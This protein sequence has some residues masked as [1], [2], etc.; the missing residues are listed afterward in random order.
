M[1]TSQI[2][3]I[4]GFMVMAVLG[5]I[6]IQVRQIQQ[7]VMVSEANFHASV[8]DA[9]NEVVDHMQGEWLR[10]QFVRVS[11]S[12][13]VEIPEGDETDPLSIR[14][15]EKDGMIPQQRVLI[16]DRLAII[17]EQEAFLPVDSII[18]MGGNMAYVYEFNDSIR[19]QEN[20]QVE[21]RGHPR[22][23]QMVSSALT[24]MEGT[25]LPFPQTWD[26]MG[27]D[28]MIRQALHNKGIFL[29]YDY[30]VNQLDE[31][32]P[33]ADL[34]RT[35]VDPEEM[36][37]HHRVKMFPYIKTNRPSYLEVNFTGDRMFQ[38]KQVW[39]QAGLALIFTLVILLSF[40]FTLRVIFRQKR[41]SEMKTDF[42]NNMTHEL[43]TPIATISL[44][45]D[46]INNPRVRESDDGLTRYAN[47]I[48]E[49]NQR[50]HRQVERVLLAAQM[51]RNKVTLRDET[52][53]IHRVIE[54]AVNSVRLQVM[55]NGGN[56]DLDLQANE[57]IVTGDQE[58]L[59]NVIYNLL[60]N[61]R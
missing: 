40:V 28:T 50:M 54:Q 2:Y 13:N 25:P 39:A 24:Q 22:A 44:A 53:D 10:T 5:I 6:V 11:R 51:D 18:Q 37:D 56:L 42:I 4:V 49:E 60:D 32:Q 26:S 16:T 61:A 30:E 57:S 59:A 20:M 43:K 47:I 27:I 1:K 19:G 48:K 36:K 45:T 15:P 9:L 34:T 14:Q 31:S 29:N 55:E 38:M 41:L 33:E 58:H 52:V 12:F 35:S 3:V 7:A 21:F 23:V 17:T 8:N 46:A